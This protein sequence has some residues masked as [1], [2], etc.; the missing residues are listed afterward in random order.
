VL[1][2][3]LVVFRLAAGA[4]FQSARVTQDTRQAFARAAVG[5]PVPG[6][7]AFATDAESVPR[8][9][10]GLAKHLWTGVPRALQQALAVLTEDTHGHAA[11]MQS[12]TARRFVLFRVASPE[13]SSS[14]W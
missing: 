12:N 10:N 1:G 4:G 8:G 9:R 5:Q 3:D 13:V 2:V 7:K 14:S 11:H 6:D